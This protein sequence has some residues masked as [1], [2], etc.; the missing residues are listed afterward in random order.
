M[1]I[2]RKR[3][4]L[5]Y[6]AEEHEDLDF[7]VSVCM[8]EVLLELGKCFSEKIY[9]GRNFFPIPMHIGHYNDAIGD[10]GISYRI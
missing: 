6:F 3:T 5:L 10:I 7:L 2:Y 8:L 9:T 1:L 4:V